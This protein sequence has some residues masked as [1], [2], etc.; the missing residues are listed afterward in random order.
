M[1]LCIETYLIMEPMGLIESES[2]LTSWKPIF[3]DQMKPHFS[4]NLNNHQKQVLR[5]ASDKLTREEDG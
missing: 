4:K 3:F 5:Y 2:S 1:I